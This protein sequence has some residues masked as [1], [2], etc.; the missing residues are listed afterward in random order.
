MN[1]RVRARRP[2]VGAD[3]AGAHAPGDL[4]GGAAD[5]ASGA[6]QE[7]G[8]PGLQACGF[9]AAPGGHVIDADRRRLVEA[10]GFGVAAQARRQLG[11]QLGMG[12]VAGEADIA[13]GAPNLGADPP[14]RTRLDHSGEIPAGD[15]RQRRLLHR[16]GDILDVARI[17]RSRHDP[18]H[19]RP[20][21]GDRVGNLS[22]MKN[23]G[24][25]ERLEPYRTHD[26]LLQASLRLL[27]RRGRGCFFHLRRRGLST[28]PHYRDYRLGLRNART[29][30]GST[31]K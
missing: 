9:E 11:D 1:R 21:V 14:G 17:D 2:L 22:H 23:R 31:E 27:R 6:D 13:A 5:A 25:A 3:H 24:I 18:H 30:T 26:L 29:S 10:E 7:H 16:A 4:G 19:R 15:A 28:A 20:L 8:L 12:S